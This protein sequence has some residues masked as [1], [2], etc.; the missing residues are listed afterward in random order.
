MID[1]YLFSLLNQY[2]GLNGFID[3]SFVFFS[4]YLLLIFPLFFLIEFKNVKAVFTAIIGS[5]SALVAGLIIGLI[6]FRPRPFVAHNVALL[7]NHLPTASFPSDHAAVS[8]AL[9]TAIFLHSRRFGVFAYAI[10]LLISISR[11]FAG[12]HYPSD[13]LFGALIGIAMSLLANVAI[14]KFSERYGLI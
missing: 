3:K 5:V 6:H 14:K 4:E 9:A 11:V 12:L 1:Y 10:A 2:A 7:V 13:I 8:F